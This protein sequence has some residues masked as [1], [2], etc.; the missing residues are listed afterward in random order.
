MLIFHL[1]FKS[2][3]YC[4]IKHQFFET[5]YRAEFSI[6]HRHGSLRRERYFISH[7]FSEFPMLLLQMFPVGFQ[8]ANKVTQ[9]KSI[10]RVTGIFIAADVIC[11]GSQIILG[12]PLP[13]QGLCSH[14]I[15]SYFVLRNI[16]HRS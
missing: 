12:N 4:D 11:N 8:G 1:F 7:F 15:L 14:L 2:F 9:H 3:S 16:F 13:H 10:T 6:R 5:H